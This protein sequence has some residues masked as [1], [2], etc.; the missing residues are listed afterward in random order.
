MTRAST[1][2]GAVHTGL[3]AELRKAEGLR[4]ARGGRSAA[5][6]ALGERTAETAEA[7]VALDETR[8]AALDELAA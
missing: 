8:T 7:P 4:A 1:K 6:T 5:S 3:R 2:A